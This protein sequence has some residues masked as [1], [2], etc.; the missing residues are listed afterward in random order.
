MFSM[1]KTIRRLCHSKVKINNPN[2]ITN[3]WSGKPIKIKNINYN[4][5]SE[6]I[7]ESIINNYFKV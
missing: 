4:K 2:K 3:P 7:E 1:I 5:K 6:L